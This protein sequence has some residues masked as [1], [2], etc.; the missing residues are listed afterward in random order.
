MNNLEHV[1]SHGTQQAHH[2]EHPQNRPEQSFF[3]RT[4]QLFKAKLCQISIHQGFAALKL[5]H[6]MSL[7]ENYTA[8]DET[9]HGRVSVK[10]DK[11]GKTYDM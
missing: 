4:K 6:K 9:K 8:F 11:N 5:V 1:R 3:E 10:Q 2:P 7:G